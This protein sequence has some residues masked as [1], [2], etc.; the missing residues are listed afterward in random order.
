MTE[1]HRPTTLAV[2]NDYEVV[3]RGVLGLLEPYSDRVD[4]LELDV[5]L[6]VSVAVDVALYDA[7]SMTGTQTADLDDVVAN[8]LIGALVV[9]TWNLQTDVVEQA[10]DRGVK[11]VV[12]KSLSALDLVG[13]IE[14][15]HGGEVVVAPEPSGDSPLVAGDWPGR[16][17]G[18]TA[19]EA[20]VV[21]LVSRGLSNTEIA[22]RTYLSINS[23]KSYIRSAYRTMGVT[24]RSQAVRWVMERGLDSTPTRIHVREAREERR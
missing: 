2:I 11:G 13:C 18:L 9:Y 3:V 15:V 8:P 6:P 12:S 20:E 4:V 7:F 10:L 19:R 5:D 23:I 16:R 21:A 17:Q 1:P 14:R 22:A 24:T